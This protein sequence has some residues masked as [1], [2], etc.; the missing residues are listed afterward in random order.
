MPPQPS[1]YY[2]SPAVSWV[3]GVCACEIPRAR[4]ADFIQALSSLSMLVGRMHEAPGCEGFVCWQCGTLTIGSQ[5]D[6][7]PKCGICAYFAVSVVTAPPVQPAL[8]FLPSVVRQFLSSL[9]AAAGILEL[10]Q[11]VHW[12]QLITRRFCSPK[13]QWNLFLPPPPYGART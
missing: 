6:P 5:L 7:C 9:P 3:L 10:Y 12:A 8:L 1:G 2:V 13:E 11:L 4:L